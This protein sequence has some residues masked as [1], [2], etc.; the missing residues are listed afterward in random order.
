VQLYLSLFLKS[1]LIAKGNFLYKYIYIN[2]TIYLFNGIPNPSLY[3]AYGQI[4]RT[5]IAVTCVTHTNQL[6][7]ELSLHFVDFGLNRS[8]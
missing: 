1:Y 8:S 6:L 2:I 7:F 4:T 5:P 3:L